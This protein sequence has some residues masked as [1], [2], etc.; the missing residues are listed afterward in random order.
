MIT[1]R[2]LLRVFAA[3][4]GLSWLVYACNVTSDGQPVGALW[5][6]MGSVWVFTVANESWCYVKSW[7]SM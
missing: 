2:P 5:Y 6:G 7:H 4:V 1:R 3:T